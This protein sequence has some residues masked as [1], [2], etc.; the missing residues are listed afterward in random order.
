MRRKRSRFC[1]SCATHESWTPNKSSAY[2][3][4]RAP[5][6]ARSRASHR[7][8]LFRLSSLSN[9][10][11][12][13][14]LRRLPVLTRETVRQNQERIAF[15]LIFPTSAA[16]RREPRG[17]RAPTLTVAY[18]RRGSRDNWAFLLRQWAWAGVAP[19]HPRITL[20]GARIVPA[21]RT[22]PPYWTYNVPER[23]I[24]MSIFHL[25][26]INCARLSRLSANAAGK[27]P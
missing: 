23:Q 6:N 18:T 16:S 1:A 4:A 27:S 12:S 24:L 2:Q 25:S 21:D 19:R 14:D 20:Y 13:N 9:F 3:L 10:T 7:S 22:E 26:A 11:S 17:R 5:G 8:V 15:R